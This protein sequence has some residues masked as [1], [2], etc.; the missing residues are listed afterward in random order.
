M[1]DELEILKAIIG[2]VTGV[3][4][5]GIVAWILYKLA[6]AGMILGA[7]IYAIKMAYALF[8]CPIT[9]QAYNKIEDDVITYRRKA[10]EAETKC[11]REVENI[12]HMYKVLKE[13]K[14][15][16]ASE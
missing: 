12:K 14:N 11:R 10:E 15:V 8:S 6:T 9:K 5:W 2:D 13:A 4:I 16:S 3:G 1:I 7:F